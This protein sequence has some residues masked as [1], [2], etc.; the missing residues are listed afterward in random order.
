M[1]GL[2]GRIEGPDDI[3]EVR[4]FDDRVRCNAE[5]SDRT[6]GQQ[7]DERPQRPTQERRARSA[8][9]R[10]IERSRVQTR[11]LF[12]VKHEATIRANERS[13]LG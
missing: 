2:R 13:P 8:V 6:E 1:K 3:A 7:R 11:D 4:E 5:G 10:K 9:T 12:A